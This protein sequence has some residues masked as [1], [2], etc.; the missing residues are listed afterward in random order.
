MKILTVLLGVAMLSGCVAYPAY[1]T[2]GYGNTYGTAPYVVQPGYDA[3]YGNGYGYGYGTGGFISPGIAY[4]GFYTAPAYGYPPVYSRPHGYPRPHGRDPAWGHRDRD[5]D[6]IPNW[7][8]RRPG[9]EGQGNSGWR[10]PRPNVG[11]P[12]P[13]RPAHPA[14]PGRPARSP[15]S[16]PQGEAAR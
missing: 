3:G 15:Q 11:Q 12:R 9:R 5:G 13:Q 4:G 16:T 7:R 10:P 14:R 8:D 6:G 1:D 2:Y